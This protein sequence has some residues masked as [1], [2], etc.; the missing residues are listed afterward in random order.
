MDEK[1]KTFCIKS[2]KQDCSI[3]IQRAISATLQQQK[4]RDQ[5][6]IRFP[7][8]EYGSKSNGLTSI[9]ELEGNGRNGSNTEWPSSVFSGIFSM[10]LY[11]SLFVRASAFLVSTPDWCESWTDL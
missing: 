11:G 10:T 1:K 3:S 8:P 7:L 5:S 4:K 6:R 9:K 2:N